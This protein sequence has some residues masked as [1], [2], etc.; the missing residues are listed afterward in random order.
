MQNPHLEGL[1]MMMSAHGAGFKMK[2]EVYLGREE[3][4]FQRKNF[5]EFMKSRG[6]KLM[7]RASD[8]EAYSAT[9]KP[10]S[11]TTAEFRY[12]GNAPE[13]STQV[14]IYGDNTRVLNLCEEI[15]MKATK[16][17]IPNGTLE[18]LLI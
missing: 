8:D 16:F 17:K 5:E 12:D 7:F 3:G 18:G 4:L 14:V 2:K 1:T 9:F 6:A 13:K 11:D 10:H 15:K